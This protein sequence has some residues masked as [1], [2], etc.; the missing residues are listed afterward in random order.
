MSSTTITGLPAAATLN[1][2]ELVAA[3]QTVSGTT[4]TVKVKIAQPGGI[5]TLAAIGTLQPTQFPGLTGDVTAS[6]GQL[7]TQLVASGVTAGTYGSATQVPQ[8]TIDGKGR[9]T[10]ASNVTISGGTTFTFTPQAAPTLAAGITWGDST[11][12]ALETYI[13]GA[14]G[15]LPTVLMVGTA[16]TT[17][18]LPANTATSILPSTYIG[19][20]TL[21]AN[22]LVAGKTVRITIRGYV[23]S[24][25]TSSSQ[26]IPSLVIGSTTVGGSAGNGSGFDTSASLF[27]LQYTLTCLTTGTSGT[28]MT[29]LDAGADGTQSVVAQTSTRWSDTIAGASST[30]NTTVA[31]TLNVTLNCT[32]ALTVKITHAMIEVIA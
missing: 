13:N 19:T 2:S 31:N 6:E 22:F 25:P 15:W 5:A 20:L 1:G 4:S 14:K 27:T 30:V 32:N 17:V 24:P 7:Y 11:Q 21:P 23:S 28:V 26:V 9:V 29:S 3:D 8:L 12:N 16:I 10:A 18:S